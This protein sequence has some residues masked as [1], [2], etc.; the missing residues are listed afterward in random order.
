MRFIAMDLAVSIISQLRRIVP[1]IR[2]ND[3]KAAE[4]MDEASTSIAL[5]LG[6][7]NR[8]QGRD[9][10]YLFTVASGSAEEVR[11]ALL[12]SIA[13]GNLTEK[14]VEKVLDDID[15]LQAILWKLMR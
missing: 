1:I 15:H 3:R 11:T 8:R 13:K 2:R 14:G 12:V 6:E 5:N 10:K 4:Q 9:K 7:G